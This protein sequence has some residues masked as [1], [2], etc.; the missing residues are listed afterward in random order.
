MKNHEQINCKNSNV[1]KKFKRR[2]L[3]QEVSTTETK[4]FFSQHQRADLNFL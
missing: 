3:F 1:H 4:T 2:Q